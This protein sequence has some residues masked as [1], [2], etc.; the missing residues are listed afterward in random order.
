MKRKLFLVISFVFVA[1]TSYAQD[2]IIK[3]NGEEIQAVITEVG[4]ADIKYKRFDYKEGPIHTVLKSEI[5]MIKYQNGDKEILGNQEQASGETLEFMKKTPIENEQGRWI[6]SAGINFA[7]LQ[8]E[9]KN[10]SDESDSRTSF[11]LGLTYEFPLSKTL[12]IYGKTGLMVS[13]KGGRESESFYDDYDY[14][15]DRNYEIKLSLL[16]LNVPFVVSYRLQFTPNF[17]LQPFGG[18]YLGY[19]IS[20]K[21]SWEYDDSYVGGTQHQGTYLN[22]GESGW[23]YNGRPYVGGSTYLLSGWGGTPPVPGWDD[24]YGNT[25]KGSS[26]KIFK[27]GGLE[28]LDMG[29]IYG[30]SASYGDVIVSLGW[31]SGLMNI[32]NKAPKNTSLTNKNFFLS[33]GYKL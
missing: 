16:Y 22:H 32:K 17:S 27:K 6:L 23:E 11:N 13:E 3:V 9:T 25:E 33:L 29:W 26:S 7:H 12:P 28:R 14:L 10:D 20:G 8:Y 24:S 30:I 15:N 5:F 1:Y 21:E 31:E 19:A 18:T 4:V 2:I